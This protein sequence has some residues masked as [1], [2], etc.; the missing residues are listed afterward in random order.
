MQCVSLGVVRESC[1]QRSTAQRDGIIGSIGK[2]V[3][4]GV[5]AMREHRML[6]CAVVNRRW[7]ERCC[8]YSE[9]WM[10]RVRGSRVG[11]ALV[12]DPEPGMV[13]VLSIRDDDGGRHK[14]SGGRIQQQH[15][16]DHV[17]DVLVCDQAHIVSTVRRSGA[18]IADVTIKQRLASLA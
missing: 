16:K 6:V 3:D 8:P 17:P 12:L 15:G 13:A 18:E 4:D 7:Q 5:T 14:V 10:M 9:I 2:F 1:C 11:N